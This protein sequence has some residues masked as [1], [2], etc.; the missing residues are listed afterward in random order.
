[1][2]WLLSGCPQF[3]WITMSVCV[4]IFIRV[5]NFF[6]EEIGCK[7]NG[8]KGSFKKI[9]VIILSIMNKYKYL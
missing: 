1:M 5:D 2:V 9:K 7:S 6:D 3:L 4:V 8:Y